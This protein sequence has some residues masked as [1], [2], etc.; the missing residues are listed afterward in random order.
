MTKMGLSTSNSQQNLLA[1]DLTRNSTRH[2]FAHTII[3]SRERENIFKSLPKLKYGKKINEQFYNQNSKNYNNSNSSTFI[4][5]CDKKKL[6]FYKGS[7]ISLSSFFLDTNKTISTDKKNISNNSFTRLNFIKSK[8]PNFR[9]KKIDD[10]SENNSNEKIIKKKKV[11]EI[12][13]TLNPYLDISKLTYKTTITSIRNK[14]SILFNKEFDLFDK[15]IPS[16]YTLKFDH[17][18]KFYLNQLHNKILSC[19]KYLAGVFLD[20]D[21]ETFKINEKILE[22]ILTNLLQLFIF[23]NKVTNSLIRH[24]KKLMVDSNREKQ[25]KKEIVEDDV[26]TQIKKLKK[27]LEN[28]NEK[29]KQIKNE[30]FQEHNDYII[31]IKKMQDEQN[32]LVKLLQKNMDYFNKYKNSQIEIKEKNNI[33]TQQKIDYNDMMDKNFFDKVQLE[34]EIIELKDFIKPIQE[35]NENINNKNKDLEEKLSL[36][37]EIMQKKNQIIYRL[38]ENLMMKDEELSIYLIECDK[39]K[40]QNDKLQFNYITLKNKYQNLSNKNFGFNEFEY[41]NKIKDD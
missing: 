33:I 38:Q 32:D 40:E 6:S 3:K 30:K 13:S 12:K 27:K 23:N 22:T 36:V 16:I 39:L 11:D 9:R 28:K 26:N 17:E 14:Y 8:F 18:T 35:E 24:T 25:D 31:S 20:Q 15:F 41:N 4:N 10:K 29:I 19:T 37:D 2:N 7:N 21:I 34:E 5:Y 1:L